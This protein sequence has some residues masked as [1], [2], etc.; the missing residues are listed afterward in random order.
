LQH[1]RLWECGGIVHYTILV[2]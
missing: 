2:L 1:R